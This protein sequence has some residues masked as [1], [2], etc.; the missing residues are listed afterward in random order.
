MVSTT[1]CDTKE[2][3]PQLCKA[4]SNPIYGESLNI[5][6]T[7]QSQSRKP[8]KALGVIISKQGDVRKHRQGAACR[9]EHPQRVERWRVHQRYTQLGAVEKILY[10]K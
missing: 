5:L 6:W 4:R 1:I 2:G 7:N 9:R 3:T 8:F 10:C